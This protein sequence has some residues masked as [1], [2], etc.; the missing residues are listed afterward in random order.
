MSRFW[1]SIRYMKLYN[2]DKNK[3]K[4]QSFVNFTEKINDNNFSG[5]T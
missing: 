5:F 2:R 3:G 4:P 1:Y